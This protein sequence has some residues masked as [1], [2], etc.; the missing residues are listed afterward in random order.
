MCLLLLLRLL[1]RNT[2]PPEENRGCI[3]CKNV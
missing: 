3:F 1:S 2:F